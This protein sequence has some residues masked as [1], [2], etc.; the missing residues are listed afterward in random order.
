MNISL[1]YNFYNILWQL[2]E[3]LIENPEKMFL[4]S[5]AKTDKVEYKKQ[6][7]ILAFF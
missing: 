2:E 1:Y 3:R 4:T 5:E 7:G 6:S